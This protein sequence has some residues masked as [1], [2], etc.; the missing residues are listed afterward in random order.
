MLLQRMQQ[1]RMQTIQ[2]SS[3]IDTCA[4]SMKIERGDWKAF[5]YGNQYIASHAPILLVHQESILNHLN[6][7]E[8]DTEHAI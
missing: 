4:V 7:H 6:L 3:R 1:S 5:R 8:N 2:K